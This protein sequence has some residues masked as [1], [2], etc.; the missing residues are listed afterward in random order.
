MAC[1]SHSRFFYAW[2]ASL[3][4]LFGNKQ[5]KYATDKPL[6]QGHARKKHALLT[7]QITA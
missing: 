1:Q 3:E 6:K 2:R 5:T 4:F 7:V